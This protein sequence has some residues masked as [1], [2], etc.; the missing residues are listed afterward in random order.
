MT[1]TLRAVLGCEHPIIQGGLAYVGNGLLAGAVSAAGA[2]GQVGS[3]GRSPGSLSD[4]IE[5]ARERAG[6][7]PFGVNLPISEHHDIGD[8]VAV[9][10]RTARHLRAV[11]LSAGNPRPYIKRFQDCGLK[12]IVVASTV[13]QAVKAATAGADVIVA[14]GYEAGGHNG[15]AEITTMALVPRMVRAVSAP[16]AAAG[17]IASGAGV[18]AAFM[19]GAQG[20]QMGTRF[21][22]ASECVAHA[23][24]KEMLIR[25]EAVDTCVMERSLGR[26]TRVLKTP[27]VERILELEAAKPGFAALAPYIGGERNRA[28]AVDGEIDEGWLNCGQGV[29]LISEI[30]PASELI[31]RLMAEARLA[32]REGMGALGVE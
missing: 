6:D 26:V 32:V 3:A 18:A 23:R 15:P 22:A 5:I 14:E 29:G 9:I 2:F 16:V 10:E 13:E 8:Y 28:A 27:L 4:E 25:A 12:V 31:E 19:L 30:M 7:K 1:D 11:S 17:G 24:Y 21:V 20:V